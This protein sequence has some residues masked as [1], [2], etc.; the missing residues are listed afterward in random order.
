MADKYMP[1]LQFQD[2]NSISTSESPLAALKQ[3][4]LGALVDKTGIREFLNNSIKGKDGGTSPSG[5]I[6]PP[7]YSVTP[8]YGMPKMG[9][10]GINPANIN[11]ANYAQSAVPPMP[12]PAGPPPAPTI[13]DVDKTN[14]DL[15]GNKTSGY[16]SSPDQLQTR[17]PQM[18]QMPIQMTQ[19]PIAPLMPAYP[20]MP[21]GGGSMDAIKSLMA[22]F[23]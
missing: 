17:N 8:N 16:Q 19:A 22:L 3:Y 11:T 1:G 20:A 13:E 23:A 10:I 9:G 4:A 7:D 5:S 2:W 14:N 21:D 18:D 6:K 15:W 12:Q